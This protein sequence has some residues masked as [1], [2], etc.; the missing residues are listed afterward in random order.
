MFHNYNLNMIKSDFI[1]G[2]SVAALA[3]PQNMAYALIAGVNP[4]YGLYTSIVSMLIATIVGDSDYMVVGPTNLMSMAIASNLSAFNAVNVSYLE[5]IIV[6]TLM[7]GIF[8]FLFGLL[9]LGNLV[10]YV[11]RPVIIGLTIGTA[12]LISAGQ[13]ENLLG[14]NIP[15]SSNLF[16]MIYLII[17]NIEELNLISL[18]IGLATIGMII[19]IEK[20]NSDYPS[21]LLSILIS[22]LLIYIFSL[23]SDIALVG[24]VPASLPKPHMINF[25]FKLGRELFSKSLSIAIIGLIQCLAVVKSLENKSGQEVNVNREF[26]GQGIINIGTAFFSGFAISGSFTNSFANLQSG[27]KTRISEFFTAISIIIFIIIFNPLIEYIP[28]SSLSGLVILVAIRMIDIEEI[29]ESF[30]AKKSDALIFLTTL[31][32]TITAPRLEYAVYLGVLISLIVVIKGSSNVDMD[33]M[34]YDRNAKNKLHKKKPSESEDKKYKIVDLSGKLDFSAS[35]NLKEKLE[36]LYENEGTFII[37]MRNI[38]RIDLTSLKELD[39]FIDRVKENKGKV[40]LTGIGN[41]TYKSLKELN[42][43]KKLGKSNIYESR[44][45]I[46]SS[47][48]DAVENI[49]D[50][51]DKDIIKSKRW[52]PSPNNQENNEEENSNE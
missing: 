48:I 13:L 24:N 52:K 18:L 29:K 34:I 5:V 40:I 41:E 23:N 27:A 2:L 33:H 6:L 35:E 38:E 46:L 31:F 44:D 49:E 1:S 20:I 28:I 14:L 30:K 22:T 17:Q 10:N 15:K 26:M 36:N 19:G 45:E 8:Q 51:E 43:D 11:S 12:I 39:R 37:R 42:I 50:F 4:I 7:V 25:S 32:T 47:T 3:L 9:R 16:S 21:Y